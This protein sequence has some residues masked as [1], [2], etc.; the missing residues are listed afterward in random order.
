MNLTRKTFLILACI[1]AL[2]T[3]ANYGIM[4]GLISPSFD[5]LEQSESERNL[6]RTLD[7][8][9]NELNHLDNLVHDWAAWDDSYE[10][11]QKPTK[12][13]EESSLPE[14]VFVNTKSNLIMYFN[15]AG[16]VI[17]G[18]IYDL[19]QEKYIKINEFSVKKLSPDHPFLKHEN[20]ESAPKGIVIT[21]HGPMMIASRPIV[22]SDETGPIG[23]TIMM[24]FFVK[25]RLAKI[26]SQTGVAFKIQTISNQ[27]L[28]Q[29][30]QDAMRHINEG[31]PNWTNNQGDK[32]RSV[33]GSIKGVNGKPLLLVR[34][35]T[36]KKITEIGTKTI[37]A[38]NIGLTLSG[39]LSALLAALFFA[40]K[41]RNRLEE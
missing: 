40:N 28:P 27:K 41:L 12:A 20:L 37:Q 1:F 25:D 29:D 16:D 11:I 14:P 17:W 39:L 10:Y 6:K 30:A 24:G 32:F 34:A 5:G 38:A 9:K 4:Q 18:K 13:Y 36:P 7:A 8:F 33:Y 3:V 22:K 35:D 23:G 19:E 31:Q 15:V 26:Q 21:E 2:L